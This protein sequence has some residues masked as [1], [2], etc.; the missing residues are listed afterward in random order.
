M[1]KKRRRKY[2]K[3]GKMYTENTQY[4]HKEYEIE[5]IENWHSYC[6]Y[7]IVLIK[8]QDTYNM[9]AQV[10]TTTVTQTANELLGTAA[11][12]LYYLIIKTDKGQLVI[13]VGEKT[14]NEVQKLTAALE[15]PKEEQQQEKQQPEEPQNEQS[16]N[17]GQST[18]VAQQNNN[19]RR[20]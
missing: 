5:Q 13:N 3:G 17:T 20:R 10:N 6:T 14:H 9:N 7:M 16:N 18:P 11:K 12:K 15:P 8:Q 19:S 4:I 2:T 1:P